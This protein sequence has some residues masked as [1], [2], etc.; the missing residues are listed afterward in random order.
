[1][2]GKNELVLVAGKRPQMRK[3]RRNG[4][5]KAKQEA[6]LAALARTCNIAA[7]LRSVRMSRS[8]LDRLRRRD[9]GFRARMIETVRE[10]YG[11]LELFTIRK[12]MDG[13]VKTVTKAD[14]SVETVH[15]Y[16]LQLAVQLLR[17][18]K[19]NAPGAEPE[20]RGEDREAVLARLGRKVDA[21]ARRLE[22]E[23][24]GRQDGGSAE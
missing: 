11:T 7:A 21:V 14:G 22:R 6:F 2:S 16:P 9:A 19:D 3:G 15:E 17:L 20:L 24:G 13:T 1:M 10:A 23:A 12:M 4:W 18:H 5:T 8:G